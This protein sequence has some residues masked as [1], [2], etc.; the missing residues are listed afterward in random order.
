MNGPLGANTKSPNNSYPN[1]LLTQLYVSGA[2]VEGRAD[3]CWRIKV[4]FT[5]GHAFKSGAY[6]LHRYMYGYYEMEPGI[7]NCIFNSISM[8][9]VTVAG[10]WVKSKKKWKESNCT[11]I[12]FKKKKFQILFHMMGCNDSSG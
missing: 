12:I 2:F 9:L 10:K 5:K 6:K 4:G 8:P 3:C 7:I 1:F 11:I